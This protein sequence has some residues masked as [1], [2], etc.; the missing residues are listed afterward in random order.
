MTDESNL[1]LDD[2]PRLGE[3]SQLARDSSPTANIE[4]DAEAETTE[5][6][7]LPVSPL[8]ASGAAFLATSAAAWVFSGIFAGSEPRLVG[9]IGPAIGAGLVALSFR[10]SAGWFLRV[11]V[12][13]IAFA[14]GVLVSLGQPGGG[15]NPLEVIA[16]AIRAGGLSQPPA[17][18]SAGWSIILIVLTSAIA[19]AAASAAM[20]FARPVLAASVPVPFAIGAVLL[21]PPSKELLSVAV[22]LALAIGALAVTFGAVLSQSSLSGAQF[23]VR[24][25]LKAGGLIA[26]I[27]AGMVGLSQIGF[28][29]PTQHQSSTIPPQKPQTPPPVS[30][31]LLFTAVMQQSVPLR[32]G[33]LDVYNGKAWLTS[34]YNPN[35]LV[36]V[37]SNAPLPRF[38]SS[39]VHHSRTPR[40]AHQVTV[41]LTIANLGTQRQVPDLAEMYSVAHPPSGMQY[42]PRSQTLQTFGTAQHGLH[43]VVTASA[44]PTAAQLNH[45]PRAP[46]SLSPFLQVPAPPPIVANLLNTIPTGLS[47]FERLQFVRTYFY[48]HAVA[49]GP[50]E[51]VDVTPRRV[52]QILAGKPA[53]PYEIAAG[54]ALLARWAGI[55]ARIGYGYYAGSTTKSQ[56]YDIYPDD[57]RM[58]LE[59]YFSGLGWV[60]I[61][62]QP[63]HATANL[64]NQKKK[65]NKQIL[66]NGQIDVQLYIP[67]AIPATRQLYT[68]IQYW[69][70]HV[71]GPIVLAPLALWFLEPGFVKWMRRRRRERWASRMGARARIIVAYA[72]FRD[73]AI[74]FNAGHPSLTPI[75]FLAIAA[76]DRDHT[77]LAWLVTRCLWGDLRRD[78][79]T[80]DAQ[81]AETMS[82]TL[83]RRFTSS[84]ALSMRAVAF[85]SRASL[86]DPYTTEIPNLGLLG[87]CLRSLR[88]G[89]ARLR[90]AIGSGRW[91]RVRRRLAIGSLKT[92]VA[93]SIIGITL[94]WPH[95]QSYAAD[96]VAQKLPR[97]PA[98]LD[99]FA[100]RREP[101]ASE[102]FAQYRS[103]ALI[104]ELALYE[105]RSRGVAVA[106]IQVARFKR[107][108][109]SGSAN[110]QRSVLQSLGGNDSVAIVDGERLYVTFQNQ[111][112][113]LV[114]FDVNNPTYEILAAESSL[115]NPE[116]FFGHLLTLEGG[117]NLD[118][119][120]QTGTVPEDV[121]RSLQ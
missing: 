88:L 93:V 86:R 19:V 48:K 3:A 55:P 121:R 52:A 27:L 9:F 102:M 81:I 75:E 20:T 32:T 31:H 99:G 2:G 73:R 68:E 26:V 94:A 64:N 57:G 34:P 29:L 16:D 30:N 12:T 120:V 6:L 113:L 13:P 83:R 103:H 25:L 116:L 59:A 111:L 66:P 89:R 56:T 18:F 44:T 10:T 110:I 39:G 61:L 42:D 54:E 84:Q 80:E 43:Y 70:F 46:K 24:R 107:S 71:V 23:E 108:V 114:H 5:E 98:K 36:N 40:P 1:L 95:Q 63:L 92:V 97:L 109:P 33:E 22:A 58:W 14:V 78:T 35:A 104:G 69:L 115:T 74:D 11:L 47:M 37:R 17:P 82:R 49:S 7:T 85:S 87:R 117:S 79:R 101:V 77:E 50:G 4:E 67:I 60:P 72:E 21:L 96:V 51:P 105:V 91:R 41:A 53:S 106:T 8:A 119:L 38:A 45:S 76:P 62:G 112:S 28:L 65:P 118:H 15:G 100:L 90:S